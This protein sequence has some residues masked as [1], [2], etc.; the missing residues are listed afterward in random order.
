MMTQIFI[1]GSSSVYGV[2]AESSGWADLVKQ[3]LHRKMYG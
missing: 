1:I 2:G 3:A